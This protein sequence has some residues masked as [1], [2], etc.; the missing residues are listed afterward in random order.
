MFQ[1][2]WQKLPLVQIVLPMGVNTPNIFFDFITF[3]QW[4][5]MVAK[6]QVQGTKNLGLTLGIKDFL[7]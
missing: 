4:K 7:Q 1:T 2:K 5:L 3:P 6:P